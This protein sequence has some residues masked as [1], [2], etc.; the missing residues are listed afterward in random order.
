[1]SQYRYPA[2]STS[3]SSRTGSSRQATSQ[4]SSAA[5]TRTHYTKAPSTSTAAEQSS[6]YTTSDRWAAVQS[7]P[8]Q[9][10]D[11]IQS[12]TVQIMGD[13]R[14]PR[15]VRFTEA[16]IQPHRSQHRADSPASQGSAPSLVHSAGE[17]DD[18]LE[19]PPTPELKPT[20]LAPKRS[21]LKPRTPAHNAALSTIEQ[22]AFEVDDNVVAFQPPRDLDFETPAKP[23]SDIN[24]VPRLAYTAQT[25]PLLEHIHKL[26]SLQSELDGIPSY[27]DAVIRKARK[28]AGSRIQKELDGLARIQARF[29]HKQI[30]RSSAQHYSHRR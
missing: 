20:E 29:W 8:V 22:I 17:H 15:S 6:A 10:S 28:E 14:S 27:G 4:S 18:N 11:E 30:Q 24:A 5:R 1:M 3:Q 16:S 23:T 19:C 26:E 13:E 21:C 7:P 12:P 9:E 25:R 2:A